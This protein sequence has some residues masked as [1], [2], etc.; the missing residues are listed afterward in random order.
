MTIKFEVGTNKFL[1]RSAERLQGALIFMG[2][3]KESFILG[4]KSC[5]NKEAKAG[6]FWDETNQNHYWLINEYKVVEYLIEPPS[7]SFSPVA[8]P[9]FLDDFGIDKD[10][11]LNTMT[12]LESVRYNINKLYNNISFLIKNSNVISP[13]EGYFVVPHDD[14]ID[15][16]YTERGADRLLAKTQ[17][18]W[19]VGLSLAWYENYK[20]IPWAKFNID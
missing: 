15:I 8:I 18:P 13:D 7:A 14:W 16:F 9:F 17:Y 5:N 4:G 10:T 2:V 20:K 11:L 3:E 12:S 6:F 19:V 1:V